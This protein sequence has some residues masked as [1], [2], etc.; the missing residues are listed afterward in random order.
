MFLFTLDNLK[1][2]LKNKI[3]DLLYIY[4]DEIDIQFNYIF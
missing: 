1:C 2:C 3:L 4:S